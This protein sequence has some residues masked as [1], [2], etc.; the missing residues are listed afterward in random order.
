MPGSEK[1][2]K[3]TKLR[4]NR[5]IEEIRTMIRNTKTM[6]ILC[7]EYLTMQQYDETKPARLHNQIRLSNRHRK[8]RSMRR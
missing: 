3:G 5:K 8:D 7:S 1:K 2:G 6:T 4:L